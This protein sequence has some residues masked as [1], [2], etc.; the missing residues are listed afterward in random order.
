M[1]VEA[2]ELQTW[3][4]TEVLDSA[5]EKLGKLED[6]YFRE[7]EP[8]VISIRSG[9]GGRKHQAAS[10]RGAMAS[11]D[12]LQLN[13]G[14][15]PVATDTAGIGH[16]QLAELAPQ[17]D[18]LRDVQPDDLEGWRAREERLEAQAKAQAAADKLE[19]EAGQRAQDEE[20]A[21]QKAREAELEAD[22]ARLARQDAEEQARRAREDAG[23]R[24]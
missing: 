16:E 20:A 18:R 8:L 24:G 22:A 9:L 5:G 12:G 23:G 10:L 6:V 2:R 14:T 15:W 21:A 7:S 4:G 1:S 17:D 3:I 13:A 11:R 19:A